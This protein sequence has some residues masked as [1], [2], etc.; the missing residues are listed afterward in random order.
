MMVIMSH[1]ADISFQTG[2]PDE[3]TLASI[4]AALRE[5]G[6]VILED[7][8]DP[9]RVER[10]VGEFQQILGNKDLLL[11]GNPN[12]ANAKPA[13]LKAHGL[14]EFETVFLSRIFNAISRGF[15]RVG[16]DH[17]HDIYVVRDVLG[18]KSIAQALHFDVIRQLKFFVCLNDMT[19]KNGAFEYVPRS[20][21]WTQ[22]LRAKRGLDIVFENRQITRDLPEDLG[23]AISCEV[24]AGTLVIFDT[25]IFHRAGNV[26]EGERWV[27]RGHTWPTFTPLKV[28]AK[29]LLW[30]LGRRRRVHP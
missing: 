2:I 10:M 14:V 3:S 12:Q 30:R 8:L 9:A 6:V 21:I 25:E 1:R 13:A 23:P 20:H 16:V 7:F 26:S 19:R 27:A 4:Q 5:D 24:G 17:C 18:S 28:T 15:W 29:R 11:E 22:R